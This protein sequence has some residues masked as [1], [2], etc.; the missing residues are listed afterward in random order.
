[1]SAYYRMSEETTR[2]KIES[3][4]RGEES[5]WH[6]CSSGIAEIPFGNRPRIRELEYRPPSVRPGTGLWERRGRCRIVSSE[7]KSW[8]VAEALQIKG[9][10]TPYM[11]AGR[12]S[13]TA[14]VLNWFY[15]F[16]ARSPPPPLLLGTLA[17]PQEKVRSS[18]FLE[19]GNSHPARPLSEIGRE[20]FTARSAADIRARG[21]RFDCGY[22]TWDSSVIWMTIMCWFV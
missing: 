3:S 10:G 4:E 15:K 8:Y 7:I 14:R 6:V 9:A 19:K 21:E 16:I 18:G 13:C 17:E 20:K 11:A 1:M 5:V 2:R 12:G 22:F